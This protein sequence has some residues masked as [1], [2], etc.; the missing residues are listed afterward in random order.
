MT[1]T[2]AMATKKANSNQPE[3]GS[4]K[5]GGGKQ[6][7]INEATT[8]PRWWVR[9]N[10]QSMRWMIMAALKRARVERGMVMAI[11]VAGD[12]EGKGDNKKDGI[13]DKGGVW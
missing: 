9:T 10:D 4:T 6:E 5:A 2:K 1:T 13:G 11:R 3:T 8:W 7:S 12:K